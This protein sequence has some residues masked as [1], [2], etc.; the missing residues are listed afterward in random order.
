MKLFFLLFLLLVLPAS[1]AETPFHRGVNLSEWFQA[2][3]ARSIPFSKFTKDDLKNI[4]S[5][6]CD[7]IR[8][9]INLHPMTS[10]AP[11]YT[12]DPLLFVFLDQAVDWAEELGIHIILDNH[13]FDPAASTPPDIWKALVPVWKQMALHF[14]DRTTL[15]Y[16]EVLNEP[17]GISD[18]VWNATQQIVVDSIRAVD[19][20]HTI[21]IGPAGWNSYANLDL[22]PLYAD[23]NII[24]TFHFYDPFL[25]THQ[26]ASWTD[27]SFVPISGIPFPYDATRMPAVPAA[28]AGTYVAGMFASYSTDGTAAQVQKTLGTAVKFKENRKVRIFCGEFGVFKPNSANADRV[29][30]YDTVR[31]FLERNAIAWTSWDYQGGFGLFRSGTQELFEHDLNVPLLTALGLTVPPQ[32][33]FVMRAESTAFSL[34]SDYVGR[35]IRQGNSAGGQL[36]M[37]AAAPFAGTYCIRWKDAEQYQNIGFDLVPDKDLSILKSQD[38]ALCFAVKSSSPALQF[39]MRFIDTKS[40]PLDHPWRMRRTITAPPLVWDGT[41]KQVRIRLSDMTEHGAWDSVWYNPVGAFDWKAVDRFEIVAEQ[42]SLAGKELWLDELR[43]EPYTPAA[44]EG[45]SS[46]PR[47]FRLLPNYPNPFNPATTIAYDV[48]HD[49]PV[50][51]T[52]YDMLGRTVALLQNG[53]VTAGTHSLRFDGALLPSG[54]YLCSFRSDGFS[55]VQKLLLMK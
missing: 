2:S 11:D 52:V 10:G 26:G 25:F 29:R 32:S 53:P 36:D 19:T 21:I 17:H 12:I 16:Y 7:V 22:M 37:Y 31:T 55:A 5:L 28:L 44:A 20:K 33:P 8:L 38:Y 4:K 45:I 39:D 24:Y 1:S 6:G 34:Y 27:P 49:A 9:P 40:G 35:N 30:W 46:L 13:T 50:T 54:V 41:W 51:V 3:S 47:H 23:T 42:G 18:A 48:P 14:R 43:I 15:V